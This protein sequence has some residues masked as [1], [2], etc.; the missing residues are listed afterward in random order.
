MD[1]LLLAVAPATFIIFF[2]YS[3]DKFEKEPISFL[4]KNFLLGA[5]LSILITFILSAILR[6]FFNINK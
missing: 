5:T 4:F 6:Y 2:I 3:K 1:L